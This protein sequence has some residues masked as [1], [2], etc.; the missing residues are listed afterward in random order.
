MTSIVRSIQIDR[1]VDEVWDFVHDLDKEALWQTTLAES[2]QLTEGPM[3]VG[4]RVRQVRH[5]LGL[6]IPMEWEVTEYEP[7][8]RSAIKSVSGPVPL[9]GSYVLEP[10]D[11]GTRLTV[12]GELDAHGLFMLAEPV[13]ARITGRE[14]ESN[15]GHL[16]DLL[17]AGGGGAE[18]PAAVLSD[19]RVLHGRPAS[20]LP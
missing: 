13:F 18:G 17:E 14:L 3:R 7:S 1:P 20:L 10:K 5:F 6:R 12:S 8:T 11:G 19:E 9:S 15:L 16:K 4:T 2:E